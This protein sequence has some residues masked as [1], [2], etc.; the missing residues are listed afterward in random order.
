M[1][2]FYNYSY[3]YIAM[4]YSDK[5]AQTIKMHVYLATYVASYVAIAI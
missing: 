5:H 4:D 2:K 1:M 3:S